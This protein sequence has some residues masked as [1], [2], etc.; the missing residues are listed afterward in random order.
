DQRLNLSNSPLYIVEPE[1]LEFPGLLQPPETHPPIA[2]RI[3]IL[4]SLGSVI[5]FSNYTAVY[6]EVLNVNKT[7]FPRDIIEDETKLET[8]QRDIAES[9]ILDPAV[10][11]RKMKDIIH[12][13]DNHFI[14]KC[15]CGLKIKL[16]KDFPCHELHCPRCGYIHYLDKKEFILP[17]QVIQDQLQS[18]TEEPVPDPAI[19]MVYNR[20]PDPSDWESFNCLCGSP[21]HLSPNFR[22]KYFF[23]TNCGRKIILR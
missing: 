14:V 4:R 3:K 13:L 16:P 21:K 8:K 1:S 10:S 17:E 2:N 12:Y 5:S 11:L 23:C 20:T 9:N 6:N 22:K 7:L 18:D 19:P 15:T